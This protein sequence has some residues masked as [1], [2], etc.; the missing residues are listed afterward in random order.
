MARDINDREGESPL[1]N[2]TPT[3]ADVPQLGDGAQ[4]KRRVDDDG[5]DNRGDHLLSS[6]AGCCSPC[7]RATMAATSAAVMPCRCRCWCTM[8]GGW[9]VMTTGGC[10]GA[11]CS[12]VAR[13]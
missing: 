12:A 6:M 4:V 8:A 7:W 10:T 5:N 3:G 2:G 1:P 9:L 13:N 11:T